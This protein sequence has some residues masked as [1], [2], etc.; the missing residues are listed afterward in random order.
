M[1]RLRRVLF[2]RLLRRRAGPVH[3]PVGRAPCRTRV[4]YEVQ[5]GAMLLVQALLGLSRDGFTL[6][7]LLATCST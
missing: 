3:A 7:A 2:E 6:V 1:Q 5:T 4:V